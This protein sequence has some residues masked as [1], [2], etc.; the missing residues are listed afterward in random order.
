MAKKNYETMSVFEQLTDGLTDSIEHANG[1]LDLRSTTLPKPA[2]TPSK[3]R[4]AA[5][6][7]KMGMSQAVFAG[8][9]NVPTR[10]LQSWEQGA[11]RPKASEARLL[12]IFE[13]APRDCLTLVRKAARIRRASITRK[14]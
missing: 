9:L 12:Q 8:Y 2:P 7:K 3:F 11:R 14:T 10:T 4:V 1:R 5:I 6:R 13:A